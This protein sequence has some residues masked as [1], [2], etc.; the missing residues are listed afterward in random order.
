MDFASVA[1]L[2][3]LSFILKSE[4]CLDMFRRVEGS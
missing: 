4:A 1:G 3:H 2:L